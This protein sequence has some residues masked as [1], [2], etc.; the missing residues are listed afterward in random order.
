MYIGLLRDRQTDRQIDRQ[1]DI[2]KQ[3]HISGS[4][5]AATRRW[6]SPYMHV[7]IYLDRK[8]DR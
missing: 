1:T 8:T 7:S 2:Y 4:Q 3:T 5:S 6:C